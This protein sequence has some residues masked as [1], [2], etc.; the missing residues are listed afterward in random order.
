MASWVKDQFAVKAEILSCQ[1]RFPFT[2]TT[3]GLVRAIAPGWPLGLLARVAAADESYCTI[4]GGSRVL[5][6]PDVVSWSRCGTW[7]EAATCTLHCG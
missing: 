2:E 6:V 5:V 7:T 4:P 3:K 1:A